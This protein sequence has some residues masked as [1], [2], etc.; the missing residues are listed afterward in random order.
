MGSPRHVHYQDVPVDEDED[1]LRSND[2]E[3]DLDD[4]EHH[5]NNNGNGGTRSRQ[6]R[7]PPTNN[8][9]RYL[10]YILVGLLVGII[11]LVGWKRL[12]DRA[13]TTTSIVSNGKDN[14][15]DDDNLL[16]GLAIAKQGG[17]ASSEKHNLVYYD[18]SAALH[19]F[20]P[21]DLQ[22][23]ETSLLQPPLLP[24]AD[25][26]HADEGHDDLSSKLGYI[27]QPNIVNDTLV[28]VSEGDLYLTHLGGQNTN[29]A[30]MKLTTTVGNV[31]KPKIN[32]VY[33]H[34]VAY[35]ATYTGR[36]EVYLLDLRGS[37]TPAL[38]LTYWDSP[39]GISSVVGWKDDGLSL[40]F[41]A[42]STEIGL[43]DVRLYSMSLKQD[44]SS[45]KRKSRRLSHSPLRVWQIQPIPLTQAI[46]GVYDDTNTCLYF[47]R[48]SQ[49]SNTI[50]YVGGTAES[51][52]VWCQQHSNAIPLT[53]DYRGTDKSPQILVI[54]NISYLLFMS[55]RLTFDSKNAGTMELWATLLLTE[56]QLYGKNANTTKRPTYI[57]LTQVACDFD[58]KSLVEYALDTKTGNVILRIGA[59]LHI[60]KSTSI[61]DK[62]SSDGGGGGGDKGA[63]IKPLPLVV[64]SDFHEHQ[65]R[66]IPVTLPNDVTTVDVYETVFGSTSALLGLRGQ[67]W[68][69]PV[70]NNVA[71]VIP[72]AGAGMNLPPRRYRV[73]PG[74]TAGGSTRIMA[75]KYVP[76]LLE[77][78]ARR[79]ALILA[80]DP[81]SDTAEHGFYLIETQSDSP[82]SFVD[83]YKMPDP[84]LGGNV[85]GGSVADGGL[86]TV[87]ADSISVSPC[88]RRL[89]WTD[90]DGRICVMT[91]PLYQ[92]GTAAYQVL[93]QQNE[94]GEPMVG[95]EADLSWSPGG[96]YLAISHSA[97]NQ[98]NI[99]S[100]A[101]CGNPEE[102]V[103]IGRIVQAT[104][105]RFNSGDPYWGKTALDFK[106]KEE[107]E[108]LSQL[109]G[110]PIT[111]PGGATVLYFLSDR[112]IVT[113]VPS[114]WGT[115]GPSPHFPTRFSI[116]ALPLVSDEDEQGPLTY[117]KGTFGGGGAAELWVDNILALQKF[118][119]AAQKKEET[120]TTRR[121]LAEAVEAAKKKKKS[122]D[123]KKK[124]SDTN[125]AS[126]EKMKAMTESPTQ[127]PTQ[128]PETNKVKATERPTQAPTQAPEKNKVKAA[129]E[130]PTHAPT[131]A[132]EKPSKFPQDR[133]IDFGSSQDLS[134]ARRAYRLGNIPPGQ[135][136]T[137]IQLAD[138]PSL[139]VIEIIGGKNVIKIFSTSEFP[140]DGVEAM[141]VVLPDHELVAFSLTTTREH[142]VL[143]FAPGEIMKVVENTATGLV[144]F[145]GDSKLSQNI[146]DTNQMALSVWPALEYQQM[147]DDAWRL[148][149]DYFYDPGMNGV[150]WPE[151]HSRYRALVKR[152]AK[153]E[154]LDDVLKQMASE[155]SALHVFVHGGEYGS[156]LHGSKLLDAIHETASLGA[157][158]M[159][160]AE[161]KGYVVT[162]IPERD[163]DFNLVDGK[164]TYSPLSNRTLQL[165]GQR[166]LEVGDV[167]VGVN[168]ESVMRVPDIHMLLR[169]LSGRS[170]RLDVLRLA[171]GA[172][173]AETRR[174]QNETLEE[175]IALVP[176]ALITV[177]ISPENSTDLLYGAWEWQ[178]RQTAKNLA[179][180]AN[181]SVGYVHLRS[182]SGP[183]DVDAFFRGFYPDY[184]KTA[185]I[186]DVRHNR[187]GN[188]DSWL[189]D[190]LQRRAWMYWQG[191]TTNIHNGGLG[192]DE[193]FAFRGHVVVLIDEHTSS[194]GEGFSRG[195]SELGLGKLIG[196]RTWGG[197]IWLSSDNHLVDGGIATAPEIGTYNDNFGWGLGIEQMGVEPDFEVENDPRTFYDGK[198]QQLE[199]AIDYLAKWLK[200]EPIVMPKNPGPK[201]DMSLPKEAKDCRAR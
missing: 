110:Q 87:N 187:G 164:A 81:K 43:P 163:P 125:K 5:G 20:N 162:S 180:E 178:T 55:D 51:I 9:Q 111:W 52:W 186:I 40:I 27:M 99:I 17:G 131:K 200:K 182:M 114:P 75:A 143:F 79:L 67:L 4:E 91:L 152:C 195:V 56:T 7:D 159:R 109:V 190:V 145:I 153:R 12:L 157:T 121:H 134:F 100:I 115:R 160:S 71:K 84:F 54:E 44:G 175:G 1:V 174:L 35:T 59:D 65:E 166:G 92:N 62:L 172:S 126:E 31:L 138:D 96:R 139:A 19:S 158:F 24:T 171:S 2:D 33:P 104:P 176:E 168:G 76:L 38:R 21:F 161:W 8:G 50:R 3:F 94:Q 149:R 11:A 23:S 102:I 60:V 169:G 97:R 156:P 188:I 41:A 80:T 154:E 129:T 198:D 34:Y 6:L 127:A 141:T 66:L 106:L 165:T 30:A 53:A 189:L 142:I 133:D 101:D 185:L 119:E 42:M 72:Y 22:E 83:I 170:V 95:T 201:R 10:C 137:I 117:T 118:L 103:E 39:F 37:T 181:F 47:T 130:S 155:L 69:T 68:I 132:E 148:F 89:A 108:M 144:S 64:H 88:G 194:D 86:G 128:A 61:R 57:Q 116:F 58:G 191:R 197:G 146:A 46:D 147:Y 73:G 77:N 63:K 29:T 74:I 193:Q 105:D 82:T 16:E 122:D 93:P 150:D 18:P 113:D 78:D 123:A 48:F 107:A 90:R 124:K 120:P 49:S 179:Q 135:Y 192:W 70:V 85:N 184:D 26:G 183:Q 13:P 98:F 25:D 28:F 140:S 14:G 167:I 196:K 15:N 112:D 32:P 136:K 45:E 199:Y 177:P 173:S 151:I 36:R